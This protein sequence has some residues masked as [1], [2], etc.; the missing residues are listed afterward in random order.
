M[1]QGRL[2]KHFYTELPSGLVMNYVIRTKDEKVFITDIP[3]N[4]APYGFVRECD[5]THVEN[6]SVKANTNVDFL[7]SDEADFS[8]SDEPVIQLFTN[9]PREIGQFRQV[10]E[11][12]DP[13][14]P[15]YEM[16]WRYTL[17]HMEDLG[18]GLFVQ[19][20]DDY[21]KIEA[22]TDQDVIDNL[23]PYRWVFLDLENDDRFG[24]GNAKEGRV[25]VVCIV[26]DQ[27][28]KIE[29]AAQDEK[30]MMKDLVK[31]LDNYDIIISW[32]DYDKDFIVNR[33]KKLKIPIQ[34][35]TW[36]WLDMMELVTT[37]H[38]DYS[39]SS[40]LGLEQ[41]AQEEFGEGKLPLEEGFYETWSKNPEMLS[42]YCHTDVQ[43]M[44][45][46]N[47]KYKFIEL[48]I[49]LGELLGLPLDELCRPT[50]MVAHNIFKISQARERRIVWPSRGEKDESD[51]SFTGALCV[52]PQ[53]GFYE[54][55]AIL[56]FASL[57]N[58]IMQMWHMSP[59]QWNAETKTFDRFPN[60]KPIFP[61]LLETLT[62][63]RSHYT[64]FRDASIDDVQWERWDMY[65]KAIKPPILINWGV[66]G[67]KDS[68]FFIKDVAEMITEKGRDLLQRSVDIGNMIVDPKAVIYGD[69]DSI[70]VHFKKNT[71]HIR[72]LK[73]A[74]DLADL[75]TRSLR[76]HLWVTYGFTK[77]Q[78][79]MLEMNVESVFST[80]LLGHVKKK[81][82][83]N[84]IYQDGK[85]WLPEP[86]LYYRGHVRRRKERCYFVRHLQ[87][88]IFTMIHGLE[89]IDEIVK[90][91]RI[92]KQQL[93]AGVHD[94]NLSI[95]MGMNMKLAE[96]KVNTPHVRAAKILKE[97]GKFLENM[98]VKFVFLTP[99]EVWPIG[100]GIKTRPITQSGYA[101]I[102]EK[103]TMTWLPELL[104]PFI[105]EEILGRRLEGATEGVKQ[106]TLF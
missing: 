46:A 19:I 78:C 18:Y 66:I 88:D 101:H 61:E 13:P 29:F 23:A 64:N 1:I 27:G 24:I 30:Q 35:K 47:E 21:S 63:E 32:S 68:R 51:K 42:E 65:R 39:G 20:P 96:Y 2:V 92:V 72:V 73:Q 55:V 67:K 26:N 9:F 4:H 79:D 97:M 82:C 10:L 49:A 11:A 83:G 71:T 77:E 3:V 28:Y 56:D 25:L 105:T 102:W 87:E 59:E 45:D 58:N 89:H 34:A 37:R 17:R 103:R 93:F 74:R 52:A 91:L 44:Y 86:K 6:L 57:Y 80:F 43:L 31:Y 41:F 106:T 85:G 7:E 16:D 22:I 104:E 33:C 100:S 60:R 38:P 69:T 48:E 15:T 53:A 95:A 36:C 12:Q 76:N 50:V 75:I 5:Y 99:K 70:F 90:F 62:E 54:N 40:T 84:M 94:V 81:Y 8:D 98:K 14:I